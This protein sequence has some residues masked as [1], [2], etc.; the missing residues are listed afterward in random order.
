MRY[1]AE[2]ARASE[3]AAALNKQTYFF[4]GSL[5]DVD[6]LEAV[7]GRKADHLSF[8]PGWLDG[9]AVERAAGYTFPTLVESRTGRVN[10]VLTRGL[11][12]DDA[13]RV[14]FF[15]DED[16]E[17]I[18]LDISTADSD[19]SARLYV[20]S[21]RLKSSGESWSFDRWRKH[22]KPL[23]LAITRKLMRDHYGITPISEID[24]VWHR[25]KAEIEAEMHAPVPL[26]PKRP[27]RTAAATP[28]APRRAKRATSPARRPRG[29]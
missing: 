11:T 29:S 20:A 23:L 26:K 10:G 1:V 19:I 9:Y 17:Q 18:V 22:D 12:P 7:L 13:E 5:M 25:I 6:L 24:A 4:Y 21:P 27:A 2:S 15:E 8:L 28:A 16:Y 14:A 3:L